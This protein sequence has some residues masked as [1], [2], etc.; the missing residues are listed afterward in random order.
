MLDKLP[1]LPNIT[2][3]NNMK[4]ILF[5][6]GLIMIIDLPMILFINKDMYMEQ[7][8]RIN[9]SDSV[10]SIRT[11][12]ASI[13][14]YLLLTFGIYYFGIR[15]KNFV[16]AILFGLVVYGV[17]N[18]TNLATIQKYGIKESIIDTMWGAILCGLVAFIVIKS[19]FISIPINLT[20]LFSNNS[21]NNTVVAN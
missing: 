1:S 20:N 5:I 21:I 10:F 3:N 18:T 12:F 4:A 15:E 17:Y 19:N 14:C 9:G 11:L 16:N 7:L 6:L 8:K 2:I 13:I